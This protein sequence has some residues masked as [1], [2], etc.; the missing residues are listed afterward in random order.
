[1]LSTAPVLAAPDNKESLL[2]YLA[3]TSLS[4][5]TVLAVERPEKGKIQVVQRSHQPASALRTIPITWPF[6]VWGLD[7]VGPFKTA[8]GGMT[9]LLVAVDKFTK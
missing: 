9:H 2:L 1:M 4:V 8:Q 7:K 3:A 5:S 6:A